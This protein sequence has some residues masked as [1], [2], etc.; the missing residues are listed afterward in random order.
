MYTLKMSYGYVDEPETATTKILGTYESLDEVCEA[1][2]SKFD[3]ALGRIGDDLDIRFRDIERSCC[4]CYATYGYYDCEL[5]CVV[6]DHY[7]R[8]YIID[9]MI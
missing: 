3:A 1:A 4:D 7:Y 9:T 2:E 6:A 8:V 5:G